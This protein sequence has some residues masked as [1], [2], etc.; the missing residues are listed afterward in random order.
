VA[1]AL[2]DDPRM[3]DAATAKRADVVGWLFVSMAILAAIAFSTGMAL[4]FELALDSH[5]VHIG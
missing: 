1:S 2:H 5:V 3:S 4:A